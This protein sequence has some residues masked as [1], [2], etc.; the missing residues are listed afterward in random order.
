MIIS[1][2]C[3]GLGNQMFQY[4]VGRRLAQATGEP[5]RLDLTEM[6]TYRVHRYGLDQF[7]IAVPTATPDELPPPIPKPWSLA[8]LRA[9]LGPRRGTPMPRIV[10]RTFRFEPAVLAHTG[11]GHLTGF[12]QSE[13]YFAESAATIRAD[14]RL[15][16]PLD[17]AR[18]A[19]L[20]QIEAS[21]SV[22]VHVRRGDY[23]TNPAAN[24]IH[25]TCSPEWYEAAIA[26]AVEGLADPVIFVFSDDPAWVR[27]NLRLPAGTVFVD[28][29]PDGR[30]A[31]DM[32]LMAAAEAH[33]IANSTFSWW[34]AWLD[35][36]PD[37]RVVAPARWFAGA[38]HDT[39]DLIPARWLRL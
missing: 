23:V 33:V 27:A 38:D 24:A 36:R 6:A 15:A 34:A 3:G 1:R 2:I 20:A 14:F 21:T 29:R 39:S 12:W 31:A 35:P 16:A 4:A 5:Y 19:T 7:A 9:A 30:D 32:T 10:E 8:A 28:P 13:R 25:G 26:R 37:A 11:P 17:A 22:S 18:A